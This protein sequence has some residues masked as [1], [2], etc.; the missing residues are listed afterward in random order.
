MTNP[1]ISV[2][3][4]EYVQR[5]RSK[6]FLFT[7]LGLPIVMLAATL[8]PIAYLVFILLMNSKKT[9]GAEIPRKRSLVNIL[10]V[11]SASGAT[12][13][14]SGNLSGKLNSPNIYEHSFAVAGLIGLPVLFIIGI[15]GFIKHGRTS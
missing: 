2:I 8:L 4:R 9:L 6:W 12:V 1:V 5:V 14:A 10:M 15:V 3:R 7:T 11:I 13:A